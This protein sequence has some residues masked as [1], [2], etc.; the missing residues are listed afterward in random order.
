MGDEF[1]GSRGLRR[2]HGNFASG[3]MCV[4][5]RVAR[6]RVACACQGGLH[7]LQTKVLSA[8]LL[9]THPRRNRGIFEIFSEFE[10]LDAADADSLGTQ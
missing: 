5:A 7:L 9:A 10:D 6:V 4:C 1:Q 2:A 8:E 3:A